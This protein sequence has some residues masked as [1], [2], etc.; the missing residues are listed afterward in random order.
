MAQLPA[1]MLAALGAESDLEAEAF[2][3]TSRRQYDALCHAAQQVDRARELQR[4]GQ[5]VPEIVVEHL[6][7]C[8]ARLG[9]ITGEAFSEDVLSS[10]FSRFCIGK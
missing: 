6:R 9:E 2:C 8:L 10:V 7:E 5:A 3:V 1:K 4:H